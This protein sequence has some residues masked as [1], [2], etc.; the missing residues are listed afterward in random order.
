MKYNQFFLIIKG[1]GGRPGA[2][3][4]FTVALCALIVTVVL[5]FYQYNTSCRTCRPFSAYCVK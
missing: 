3:Q 4:R 5:L 1:P 2:L